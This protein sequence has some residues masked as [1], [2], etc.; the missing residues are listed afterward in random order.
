MAPPRDVPF[1][2]EG[3]KDLRIV[4]VLAGTAGGSETRWFPTAIPRGMTIFAGCLMCSSVAFR[5][6]R[7]SPVRHRG[8]GERCSEESYG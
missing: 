7:G 4:T 3:I 5:E 1:H 2:R 6:P 8:F